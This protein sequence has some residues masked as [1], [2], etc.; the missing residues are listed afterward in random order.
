MATIEIKPGD[1]ALF[2]LGDKTITMAAGTDSIAAQWSPGLSGSLGPH[3][4]FQPPTSAT[5]MGGASAACPDPQPPIPDP[6]G[7]PSPPGPPDL[8]TNC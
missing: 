6:P 7:P 3:G 4:V 1:T 2:T 5:I 8:T